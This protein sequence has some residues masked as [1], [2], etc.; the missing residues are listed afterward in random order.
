MIGKWKFTN[1]SYLSIF[2]VDV[3]FSLTSRKKKKHLDL[4]KVSKIFGYL[5]LFYF[6]KNKRDFD[7][8]LE[9]FRKLLRNY[10]NK[11]GRE[12]NK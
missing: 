9:G 12:I 8:E 1:V 11:I 6:G 5:N 3:N 10:L 7:L 4:S 2:V